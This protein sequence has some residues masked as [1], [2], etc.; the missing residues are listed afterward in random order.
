MSTQLRKI[1]TCTALKTN[2][3]DKK[4][5]FHTSRPSA[6]H[7]QWLIFARAR[8]AITQCNLFQTAQPMAL[9]LIRSRQCRGVLLFNNSEMMSASAVSNLL[10]SS[11][12]LTIML[13]LLV[14]LKSTGVTLDMGRLEW[15]VIAKNP[16]RNSMIS[17]WHRWEGK[18]QRS[19]WI[20]KLQFSSFSSIDPFFSVWF[21]RTGN[22]R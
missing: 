7:S 12:N 4:Q 13:R 1:K 16:R 19:L 21:T 11:S 17:L 22:A 20:F 15:E 10:A 8:H 9:G 5:F 6:W 2:P 14:S 18:R 3:G